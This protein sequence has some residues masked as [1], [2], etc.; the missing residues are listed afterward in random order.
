M[1]RKAAIAHGIYLARSWLIGDIL[2][3]VEA[4]TTIVGASEQFDFSSTGTLVYASGRFSDAVR[5][6][7]WVDSTGTRSLL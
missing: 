5:P 7:V 2:D 3:D 6:L 1:V 4:D